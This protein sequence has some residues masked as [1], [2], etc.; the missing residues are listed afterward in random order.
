MPLGS[1]AY[2]TTA[3]CAMSTFKRSLHWFLP[4][5]VFL[6]EAYEKIHQ[7]EQER[8]FSENP[9]QSTSMDIKAIFDNMSLFPS[10]QS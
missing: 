1:M 7:N 3:A 10:M 6:Y 9:G 5:S 4:I 8:K 2:L